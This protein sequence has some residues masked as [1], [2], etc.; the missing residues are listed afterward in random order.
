[1]ANPRI[2]AVGTAVPAARFA[3]ADLLAVAGYP[4]ALRRN[5][6]LRSEIEGRH[7]FIDPDRPRTDESVD[8]LAARYREGSLALG[9]QA[10]RTCLER[11]DL[12]VAEVDFL[13][14]TTCT[15]RLC[16]S[17]D[18]HLIRAL[19]FRED[20]QRVHVGDTGC[21]SAMVALQQ[22]YNHLRAFPGHRA[23]VVAVEVCSAT[24]VLDDAPE[25]A[26]ANAIFADGA[27]ATLLGTE[28]DGVAVVGHR[29]LIRS[30]HLDRMGFTFPGGR[31]RVLLSKEIRRIAPSMMEEV[32]TRLLKDHGLAQED[33]RF[34]VLH[35][36][37]RR[38]IER[39]Q[40]ALGLTDADLAHSRAVLRRFGNM[41]SATVLFV[42]DEVLRSGRPRPGDWG[43]MI[44]LGPGFAAESALLRW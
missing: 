21:A 25:T 26:V 13:A 20:V 9:T 38:V 41:S 32:A 7:L 28:G 19:G 3:Q 8:E 37:G 11:A 31:H 12:D 15:G 33:V 17:L 27:A 18:A 4:D 23:L 29:T 24:Y 39:A 2:L 36:A 43:V 6:F 10:I 44:A 30:E 16:P 1:M 40:V 42:L 35:S 5:F 14:T 22:A 34:W